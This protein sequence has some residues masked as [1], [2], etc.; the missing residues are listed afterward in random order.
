MALNLSL[1]RQNL[2]Y[3]LHC[4]N[5]YFMDRSENENLDGKCD[6][7]FQSSNWYLKGSC[8]N[9]MEKTEKG[10]CGELVNDDILARLPA[11]PF[12]MDIRS[13]FT[14]IT[15]WF[16]GFEKDLKS[17]S[18]FSSLDGAKE[19]VDD[20][21]GGVFA[22]LN[23]VWNG[24]MRFH[25]EV[26]DVKFDEIS[27]PYDKV[28]GFGPNNGLFDGGFVLDGSLEDF[29][30]YMHVEDRV[31]NDGI[32]EMGEC[33]V[34]DSEGQGDANEAILYALRFLHIR[35]LFSVERVCKSLRDGIRVDNL[36]WRNI[37]IDWPL[38]ERITDDALVKLTS[39]AEGTVESLSL[40]MCRKIT[41]GGL[42]RVLNNN[43]KLK[44][45]GVSG[46]DG[47]SVEGIL[48]NLRA[49]KSAGTPGIKHLRVCGL[50]GLTNEHLEELKSLLDA[51]NKLIANKPRLYHGRHSYFFS[52]DDDDDDRAIDVESCPKCQKPRLVYDCPVESCREKHPSTQLC[53]ACILCTARCFH[54]GRC[55]KDC[56]YEETFCLELL[57]MDCLKN[58]LN[59]QEGFGGH[60]AVSS[61]YTLIDREMGYGVCFIG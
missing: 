60:K 1:E 2:S 32:K 20:G 49:M 35:D 33:S 9:G 59:G 56:E 6:L 27:M 12:E 61:K 52:D 55:I 24:A 23:W 38:N 36:L 10:G 7:G 18:D 45:L 44:K 53:R 14:T 28:S 19:L 8:C 57:C 37:V 17:V 51:D 25:S 30:S 31:F 13:T 41:D 42:K 58:L 22:G 15:G 26:D 39:K 11:D 43:P 3:S 47:I 16:E 46:C 40:V 5:G 50:P 4:S 48:Y 54:C 34:M 21:G 29:L